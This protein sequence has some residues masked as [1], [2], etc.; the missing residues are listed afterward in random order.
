MI[1][2]VKQDINILKSKVDSYK[3]VSFDLFDTLMFRTVSS[4]ND[5]YDIVEILYNQSER[6]NLRGFKKKRIKAEWK[7]RSYRRE[8]EI[9]ID[10]IYHFLPYTKEIKEKLQ[11]IEKWCEIENCVPNTPMIEFVNWC[12]E[13]GKNIVIISDMYLDRNTIEAILDKIGVKFHKLF[14]SSDIG[15]TK[16]SGLLFKYV[17]NSLN[18]LAHEI[19]HIGDDKET[20]IRM[21]KFNGI[22]S[23]ERCAYSPMKDWYFDRKCFDVQNK[24]MIE[25]ILNKSRDFDVNSLFRIGYSVLGPLL[26]DFCIWLHELKEREKLDKLLF[27]A[28]EGYLIKKIYDILYPKEVSSND[29][30]YLNKNLLRLPILSLDLESKSF[31]FLKTIVGRNN[32]NLSVILDSLMLNI[33]DLSL[34]YFNLDSNKI[35]SYKDI[36][37]G[38]YDSLFAFLF[39]KCQQE[40]KSQSQLLDYYLEKHGMDNGKIGLVNNSIN[41]NGQSL[42]TKYF[43]SKGIQTDILGLQFLSTKDC[44]KN[45]KGKCYA[46]LSDNKSRKKIETQFHYTCLLFEHLL[47]EPIGT[48]IKFVNHQG[49]VKVEFAPTNTEQKDFETIKRIQDY[50]QLFAE[51]ARDHIALGSNLG[52]INNYKKFISHPFTDDAKLLCNLND[53]EIDGHNLISDSQIPFRKRYI[54]NKSVPFNLSWPEGYLKLHNVPPLLIDIFI[55]CRKFDLR[56]SRIQHRIKKMIV[57]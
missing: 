26:T 35:L 9:D 4:P 29:Y 41:G 24:H 15:V 43:N 56:F 27:V 13:E 7:A 54:I 23:I 34:K 33:D 46:W 57:R 53:D 38:K 36:V 47:F 32:Y 51:D 22:E 37:K 11:R 17:L 42:L 40:I 14:L 3:Y 48:A 52:S 12:K 45:L 50:A 2:G 28:R 21:A 6:E 18:I 39:D 55:R 20:D 19:V 49:D 16:R 25:L 8:Q 1:M 31:L 30:I 5:I 10:N 44:R